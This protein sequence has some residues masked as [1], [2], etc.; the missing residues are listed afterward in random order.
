MTWVIEFAVQMVAELFGHAVGQKRPWWVELMAS[1]GCLIALGF[2]IL[3][4]WVLL[5]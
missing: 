5:R 3:L 2:P 1:L 4:L